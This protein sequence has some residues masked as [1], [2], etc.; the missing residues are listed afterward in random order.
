MLED[1]S[2]AKDGTLSALADKVRQ[3]GGDVAF[4][5]FSEALFRHAAA[6]DLA[7]Y[8]V[9][10][11]HRLAKAGW[12]AMQLRTPG[13]ARIEVM[14]PDDVNITEETGH[15]ITVVEALNDD[16]PFLFGSLKNELHAQNLDL[17]LV[18]H[19][20]FSIERD[21]EGRLARFH[22]EAR[23][24]DGLPHESFV[25]VHVEAIDDPGQRDALAASLRAVEADVD[26]TV[27]DWQPML[28]RVRATIARFQETPPPIPAEELEEGLA[29]LQKLA[30]GDF[31][32]TG[33]RQYALD[34]SVET[35]ELIADED[36]G[37]GILRNPDI[38]VLRR[39]TDL[40]TLNS[41]IRAFLKRSAPV[42]ISKANVRSKVHRA[43]HLDYIGV[44]RYEDGALKGELRI[45]GLFTSEAYTES[46][47]DLPILRRKV[48]AV[49]AAL[50]FDPRSHSGNAV[51]N[52]LE[53]YPRDELW[54]IDE[55]LLAKFTLAILQLSERP[56]VRILPRVDPF[57]RF[58]SLLVYIPRDRFTTQVREGIEALLA[59]AYDGHISAR[60]TFMPEGVLT[61]LHLIVG[62]RHGETPTPDV[63]ELEDQIAAMTR[64]FLDDLLRA[65]LE[66]PKR[67]LDRKEVLRWADAF[68]DSYRASYA[69][70][71]ALQDISILKQ[72]GEDAPLAI[73]FYRRDTDTAARC[74][75]KIYNHVHPIPLSRRV[76]IL[77]AM[78]FLVVNE[79]TFRIDAP[80][81]EGIY[82]HD[83]SLAL[84]SGG[85]I[86]IAA[87]AGKLHGLF[88]SVWDGLAES[89]GFNALLLNAGLDW[90]QIAIL[91]ALSRYL[92]QTGI[93][94]GQG[95]IAETLNRY[96]DVARAL[97]ELFEVRFDP[98]KNDEGRA[99][100][101]KEIHWGLEELYQ[102]I[103][104]LADDT[105]VHRISNLIE[106]TLRTNVYQKDEHGEPVETFAF[107]LDPHALTGL[108]RPAPYREIWVYSPRVE[109]V[110][111]RFGAVARG[112]LRWSDRP[113]DF[114]TEILG[115]VKAQQV[116]NAVIVPVGA[117]GGFFAKQLPDRS[118][119]DAFFEEGREAYKIFINALL[120]ITDDREGGD[121]IPPKDV[122]RHDG[123]DPYLVVAADKGTATFSDTANGIAQ[124]RGFWMDDA[125]ASG[126][127][128][129]YDHKA[130][131]ITAKGAWEA[132]KRH[133]REMD[134]DI[135]ST[136]F[137]AVGVGD[138]SGDV[139]GN[140]ML[141]SEHTKLIAAFDHRDIF[142]DPDP[143]AAKSYAERKRLF[144][145]G[146]SSWQD[147]D[148]SALSAGGGIYS[149]GAKSVTLSPEARAALGIGPGAHPPQDV[150]RAIL[151]ADADLLWFGGIGTYVRGP[152]E[153]NLD[154]GDRAN[155]A[156]RI[157]AG[158]LRVK[159][160]G[161]GANLGVSHKGR[162]AAAHNGVR[163]NSDAI[164][165]SA[166]V[167]TSDVEVNIKIALAE[168]MRAK[169]LS[170]ED[171]NVILEEMTDEVGDLVLRNNYLQTL[172]ISLS[173]RQNTE[174]AGFQ[175]RLM[176]VLEPRGLDRELEDLPS[177]AAL[178]ER[179]ATGEGLTR[180]EIGVLLAY[181]KL[182]LYDDI[183]QS[184]VPDD[185]YLSRELA[186]YFPKL[187]VQRF[188]DE[189]D[190]HRLRRE[191]IA[192]M[193]ANSMIN[194]GGPTF[195][196]RVGDQTGAAVDEI[197]YAFAA[198][199]DAYNLIA[200]NAEVDALDT[201][202]AGDLQ[203][204][205]YAAVRQLLLDA[206]VWFLRNQ[207]FADGLQ[208]VVDHFRR[209]LSD[210]RG[211]FND[212]LPEEQKTRVAER[213]EE[214]RAAGVPD[215]SAMR[216]ARVA[217]AKSALDI[218][219]VGDRCTIPL[220]EAGDV[221]FA[222]DAHFR[223]AGLDRI[224]RAVPVGDYYDGLALDRARRALADA[225]NRLAEAVLTT[226]TAE[227]GN[228]AE[229]VA[230]WAETRATALQR[231]ER[232][233]AEIVDG[234]TVSISRIAVASGLLKDLADTTGA[235]D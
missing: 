26:A 69:P 149:R 21:E 203:L 80:N 206:T 103:Q 127:S 143:D 96:P 72:I 107:K 132:V 194:R 92:R 47:R 231:T 133:F 166:G 45:V 191:I 77:E 32:M 164:D 215:E 121:I 197:A 156:L 165:N 63:R 130:M 213:E 226:T 220:P 211:Y 16:K 142:I 62:R 178:D 151:K 57:D 153:T 154:I 177:N 160:V 187:M 172:A 74:S 207:S 196:V 195:M 5:T 188:G 170:R 179:V 200:L 113:Q 29:F 135:Q 167:N 134:H 124:E 25:H 190:G 7:N 23:H 98:T 90:R 192:T 115:L 131:G 168:A 176:E 199:R 112:G 31:I 48:D 214:L 119:R 94:Y 217:L 181:A 235:T 95:L 171:R 101:E 17:H 141:L 4:A 53:T 169:G 83:M 137:T 1:F 136:P 225:H 76:P 79:R 159:V 78:G 108:P 232:A 58:V 33:M 173:K 84:A 86:D 118:E 198:A 87:N 28:D 218:V 56:R 180:P 175:R 13:K 183:L 161:E 209:A 128:A 34:G 27:A 11:L 186:R 222:V 184:D 224:A 227:D 106:G 15:A 147:Y 229:R 39:G 100:A 37:L 129:G 38:K 2:D 20:I 60:T 42:Y 8:S 145:L 146:R 67:K 52:I 204:E 193:L 205:L 144:E 139:F 152:Q 46:V 61:R 138:M 19:P 233:V 22:G 68:S 150:L 82:I 110:H 91:R 36:A 40:V 73:L 126:G 158:D 117:K 59:Q 71:R 85:E 228:G 9:D 162:I 43:A 219:V 10:D 185:A 97:I 66:S 54:Q 50:G 3:T 120:T 123:D 202:I 12:R 210:M 125:F 24:G 208:S 55:A 99:E 189:V 140:G 109:G 18:V 93:A 64:T 174:S 148:R 44:K 230:K 105:I 14:A 49:T 104:S 163:L 102:D 155:D 122:V 157:E 75:L 223:F 182:T 89:D 221:W 114:R 6:E 88:L 70:V 51:T 65:A 216:L 116:K 30:D 111:L 35:G 201:K 41:E 234:G 81:G 212:I